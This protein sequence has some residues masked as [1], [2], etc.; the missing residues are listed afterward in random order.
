MKLPEIPTDNLYKFM[1]IA[2]LAMIVISLMPFFRMHDIGVEG[3][4]L[5][6]EQKKAFITENEIYRAEF[7]AIP[8]VFED[9]EGGYEKMQ[10]LKSFDWINY[11]P[12]AVSEEEFAKFLHL[13]TGIDTKVNELKIKQSFWGLLFKCSV[14]LLIIGIASSVYGFACWYSKVQIY[15]DA[16][17]KKEGTFVGNGKEAGEL[18]VRDAVS[19]DGGKRSTRI[20]EISAKDN[21]DS[22][23]KTKVKKARINRE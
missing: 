12:I 3:I 7:G 10:S 6:G 2:G 18:R 17:I 20:V 21:K 22:I 13:K 14:A 15:Q 23:E 1:A 16:I 9:R 4:R 11:R 19:S 8:V 5:I